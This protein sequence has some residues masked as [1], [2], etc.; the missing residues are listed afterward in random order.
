MF[1]MLIELTDIFVAIGKDL[2]AIPMV[3][4]VL[5]VAVVLAPVRVQQ[6]AAAAYLVQF[7]LA[8]VLGLV[9]PREGAVRVLKAL[10]ECAC[11][12]QQVP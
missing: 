9:G 2:Y 4:V 11:V 6:L 8:Y 10:H 7:P 1:L 5:E 12:K 3:H